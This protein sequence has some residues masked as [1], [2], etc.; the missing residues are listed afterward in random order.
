MSCGIDQMFCS[1]DAYMHI[2]SYAKRNMRCVLFLKR[3]KE[4]DEWWLLI[5]AYSENLIGGLIQG[6]MYR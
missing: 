1:L 2:V 5:N 6:G 4:S 3:P